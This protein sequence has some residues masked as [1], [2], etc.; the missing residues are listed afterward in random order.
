M[1]YPRAVAPARAGDLVGACRR[2]GNVYSTRDVC[3]ARPAQRRADRY[4]RAFLMSRVADTMD[5]SESAEV[6]SARNRATEAQPYPFHAE[7][8]RQ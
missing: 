2:L 5:E 4:E 1:F 3:K 8:G 6:N 7:G